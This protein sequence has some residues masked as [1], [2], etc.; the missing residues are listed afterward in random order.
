[1]VSEKSYDL[2]ADSVVHFVSSLQFKCF[3]RQIVKR[4]AFPKYC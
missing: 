1:M 3:T 4:R 2:E